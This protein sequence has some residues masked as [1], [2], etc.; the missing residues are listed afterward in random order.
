MNLTIRFVL[1]AL[2]LAMVAC[3][4][5]RKSL[6]VPPAPQTQ[7][8]PEKPAPSISAPPSVPDVLKQRVQSEWPVIED[9][10]KQFMAKFKELETA[11]TK[12][13]R[14]AMTKAADEAGKIYEKL[15]D[16]W[17]ALYY[18]VDDYDEATGE[19]CRKWLRTY[20]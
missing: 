1:P 9:L 16:M 13:D 10:G 5:S 2:M 11:R 15:S 6:P 3:G 19:I 8:E 7:P 17:A 4:D 20:N 18:S 14:A 12:E